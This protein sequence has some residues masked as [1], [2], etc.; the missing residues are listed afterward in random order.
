[1]IARIDDDLHR[2]LRE[3]A[4][5]E[6]RSV[7]SLVVE[8]LRAAVAGDDARA[9]VEA[10]LRASGLLV[11]PPRPERAPSLDEVVAATRGTGRAVSEALEAERRRR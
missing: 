6:G 9:R 7:N 5:A 4:A 11:R 3:R 8:L 10:R 2:R 1:M